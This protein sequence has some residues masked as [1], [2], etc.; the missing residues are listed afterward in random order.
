MITNAKKVTEPSLKA[1]S[2]NLVVENCDVQLSKVV[3]DDDEPANLGCGTSNTQ[4]VPT[5]LLK[6]KNTIKI[7]TFNMRTGKE[8]WRFHELIHHMEAQGICIIAVQE[9]RRV[10]TETIKY[11]RIDNH[12]LITTSAWRNSALAAVGDVGF[13]LNATAEKSYAR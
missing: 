6:C 9:H 4:R 3:K 7:A 1:G 8:N 5:V 12:L 2:D 13:I 11:E 10:H